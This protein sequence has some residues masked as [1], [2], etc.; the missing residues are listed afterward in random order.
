MDT[1]PPPPYI[2][3]EVELST[4][5]TPHNRWQRYLLKVVSY[6]CNVNLKTLRPALHDTFI[7]SPLDEE[8]CYP[9]ILS[10]EEIK[11]LNELTFIT[12]HTPLHFRHYQ[13]SAIIGAEYAT[14]Y[15]DLAKPAVKLDF[16]AGYVLQWIKNF[17]YHLCNP[18]NRT[19]TLPYQC[20]HKN[21]DKHAHAFDQSKLGLHLVA[22][23]VY[24]EI[25]APN[26]E[27]RLIVA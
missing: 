9:A 27:V 8:T 4:P 1:A 7:P 26:E 11:G 2:R 13:I 21:S 15:S 25:I 6:T 19:S 24:I 5:A 14:F 16:N 23:D 10:K 17:A 12:Y 3:V 18:A 20:R 22:I